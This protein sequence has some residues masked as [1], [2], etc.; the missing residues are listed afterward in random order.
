MNTEK[1]PHN[2]RELTPFDIWE[3]PVGHEER[4]RIKW[5]QHEARKNR[6]ARR[7]A[8]WTQW[9]VA[10]SIVFFA[11]VWW[12]TH[13][14]PV[15]PLDKQTAGILR[16]ME[17]TSQEWKQLIM[18]EMNPEGVE[19]EPE[20]QKLISDTYLHWQKM[21]DDLEKLR[22]Q[23]RKN[24]QPQLLDAMI[25]NMRKQEQLLLDLKRHLNELRNRKIHENKTYQS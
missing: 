25:L 19:K 2:D 1:H 13:P 7:R 24:P 4:F 10:A 3:P 17:A 14:A 20:A 15:P 8:Q 18:S 22:N 9:F 23:Y 12:W 16:K 11:A 5:A 6:Q 21:Q